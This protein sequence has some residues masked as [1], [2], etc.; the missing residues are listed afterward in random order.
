MT[1]ENVAD[2]DDE[3]CE[4][5]WAAMEPKVWGNLG[6]AHDKREIS[7]RKKQQDLV[8]LFG[9]SLKEEY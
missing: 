9:I 8:A 5:L 2:H 1:G 4:D 6:G 7:W 3:D